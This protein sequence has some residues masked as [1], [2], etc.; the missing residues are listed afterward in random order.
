MW[1]VMWSGSRKRGRESWQ[2]R[3][4]EWLLE[5]QSVRC[6]SERAGVGVSG[7]G[8]AGRGEEEGQEPPNSERAGEGQGQDDDR[9]VTNGDES[10]TGAAHDGAAP[11]TSQVRRLT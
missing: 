3:E 6:N 8:D 4:L 10:A 11:Q 5:G 9:T 7:P 2:T 1:R